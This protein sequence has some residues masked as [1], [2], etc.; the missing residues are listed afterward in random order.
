MGRLSGEKPSPCPF[1]CLP[2]EPYSDL[3]CWPASGWNIWSLLWAALP[4]NTWARPLQL[5]WEPNLHTSL[6]FD[7]HWLPIKHK[8][9][10]R[11]WP[12]LSALEGGGGWKGS[13]KPLL[14]DMKFL[15]VWASLCR[16]QEK[17]SRREFR[18]INDVAERSA[19]EEWPTHLIEEED[20]LLVW[21]S[22]PHISLYIRTPT[23]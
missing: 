14:R 11:E 19:G 3:D 7:F 17:Q 16:C 2:W 23:S 9:I 12:E 4:S 22:L 8:S 18:H 5:P 15:T 20:D 6:A 10:L 1:P 21:T 13:C